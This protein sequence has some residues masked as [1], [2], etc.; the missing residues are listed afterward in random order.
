MTTTSAR[1]KTSDWIVVNVLTVTYLSRE[2]NPDALLLHQLVKVY[3]QPLGG[4][5]VALCV[6]KGRAINCKDAA[7]TSTGHAD[8]QMEEEVRLWKMEM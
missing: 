4:L 3:G 7:R 8:G 1:P 2:E 5:T 6:I